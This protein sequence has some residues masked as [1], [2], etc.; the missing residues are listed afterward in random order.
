MGAFLLVLA[1]AL[2]LGFGLTG[3][4]GGDQGTWT[5]LHPAGTPPPARLVHA[6]VYEPSHG[7]LIMTGGCNV[8][9]SKYFADTWAYDA[10]ANT[11]TN[12]DPAGPVPAGGTGQTLVYDLSTAK[13]ILF[14]GKGDTGPSNESWAYDPGTNTWGELDP[15]GER[16]SPRSAHSM[17]YDPATRRLIMFGGW[18]EKTSFNDTWAYDPVRNEWTQINLTGPT[19]DARWGHAAAQDERRER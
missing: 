2:G 10:A 1:L 11:W 17:V 16:P 7:Q 14:G 3:E 15:S 4:G 9:N 5:K 18:N 8:D 13:V 6:M 19:P 12:L